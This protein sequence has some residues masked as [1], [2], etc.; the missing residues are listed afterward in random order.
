MD[1]S[2]D[3][4]LLLAGILFLLGLFGVLMRRNLIFMLL[5]VEIMMNAAAL[6]FV[7]G[8]AKWKNVDGQVMVLF[9]LA[10]AAAEVAVGLALVIQM[11]KQFKTV[12]VKKMRKLKDE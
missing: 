11:Y 5:S 10:V 12:D 4:G 9:I 7:V 8:G 2:V 1:I 6:A 3:T